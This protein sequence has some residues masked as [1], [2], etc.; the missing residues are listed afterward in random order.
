[1]HDILVHIIPACSMIMNHK[2]I[3]NVVQNAEKTL[4]LMEGVNKDMQMMIV[5]N[6]HLATSQKMENVVI[7]VSVYFFTKLICSGS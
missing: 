7:I 5:V 2:I 1:M 3:V 6:V 4:K